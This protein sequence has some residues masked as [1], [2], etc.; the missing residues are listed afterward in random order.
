MEA[1]SVYTVLVLCR[2]MN[3]FQIFPF[4]SVER[5]CPV[6]ISTWIILLRCFEILNFLRYQKATFLFK[7]FLLHFLLKVVHTFWNSV[8][9]WLLHARFVLTLTNKIIITNMHLLVSHYSYF[10]FEINK[11]HF[12]NTKIYIY[13]ID[14]QH[15]P[16]LC[17]LHDVQ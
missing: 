5:I 7:Q 9:D 14:S 10:N 6:N 2:V 12:L 1:D 8:H 3:L 13:V 11:K 16:E 15:F 17:T 4:Q